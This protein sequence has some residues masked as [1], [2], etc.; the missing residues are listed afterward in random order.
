MGVFR[1]GTRHKRIDKEAPGEAADGASS[2][3]DAHAHV[4]ALLT[5]EQEI[6]IELAFTY[7]DADGSGVLCAYAP[8]HAGPP[9]S[10]CCPLPHT[11]NSHVAPRC[12]TD[13]A[14]W[15]SAGTRKSSRRR[16]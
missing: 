10:P 1:Q 12:I 2:S 6:E 4:L 3:R 15:T 11:S 8:T 13:W 5:R 9:R 16:W 7:F 14:P